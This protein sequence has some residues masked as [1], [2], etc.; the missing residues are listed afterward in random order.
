MCQHHNADHMSYNTIDG[1]T[2]KNHRRNEEDNFNDVWFRFFCVCINFSFSP[3]PIFWFGFQIGVYIMAPCWPFGLFE[4]VFLSSMR[5]LAAAHVWS[6]MRCLIMGMPR[7]CMAIVC[8]SGY[9]ICHGLPA[10]PDSLHQTIGTALKNEYGHTKST[11]HRYKCTSSL[12]L[13]RT[14]DLWQGCW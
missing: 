3:R 14:D 2:Q 11:K 9:M 5:R 13:L 8:Y 12:P 1:P 10:A 7:K 6:V 4:L